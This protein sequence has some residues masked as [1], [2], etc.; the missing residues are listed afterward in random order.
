MERIPGLDAVRGLA[1]VLVVVSHAGLGVLGCAGIV[2]VTLFFVL[3]GFLITRLLLAEIDRGGINM[4]A[5]YARRAVRLLPA[6][7]VYLVGVVIILELSGFDP[8]IWHMSWPVLF[9]STNYVFLQDRIL[10]GNDHLW[11]LAVEEHFYLVWPLLIGFA[12]VRRVRIILLVVMALLTWRLIAARADPM[13]AYVGSDT[14]AYALGMGCLLAMWMKA[15]GVS[16][17]P[18]A[19]VPFSLLVLLVLGSVPFGAIGWR[20]VAIPPAAAVASVGLVAGATFGD[21]LHSSV[22]RWFGVISYSLY[23]WHNPILR[24]SFF[25]PTPILRLW[26]CGVAI[27]I[28]WIS[29]VVIERPL[30]NSN[31]AR[32]FRRTQQVASLEGRDRRSSELR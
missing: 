15:S 30:L 18:R 19:L 5:F 9:Y 2:G 22:L 29:W 8:P 16:K 31:L 14:N 3:S 20:Q 6:L 4:P 11:S 21:Q 23:L 32:R 17:V 1:I 10:F 27:L 12:A 24:F 13:W 7:L 26:G 25:S 28:A